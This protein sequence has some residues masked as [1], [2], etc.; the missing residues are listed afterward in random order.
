MYD[1]RQVNNTITHNNFVLFKY[2]ELI[3]QINKNNNKH[4]T[5]SKNDNNNYSDNTHV[6]NIS[7]DRNDNVILNYC[8]IILT[9]YI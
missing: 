2:N 6:I 8:N 4:N 7:L 1:Q 9:L 5:I 3:A